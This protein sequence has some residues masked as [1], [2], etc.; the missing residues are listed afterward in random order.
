[1]SKLFH[2]Y[3]KFYDPTGASNDPHGWCDRLMA[4]YGVTRIPALM[5]GHI[6]ADDDPA[7]N[8]D[9]DEAK[10]RYQLTHG[11]RIPQDS[12]C[13]FN[14]ENPVHSVWKNVKGSDDVEVQQ[15]GIDF[16]H[17][18]LD[19]AENERPDVTLGI[20]GQVPFSGYKFIANE[21]FVESR[22]RLYTA[23]RPLADRLG[24]LLPE[25]YDRQ[26]WPG[27]MN[28]FGHRL[29]WLKTVLEGARYHYSG[30]TLIPMLW[31]EYIDLWRHRPDPDTEEAQIARQLSGLT[32]LRFNRIV[33]DLADGVMWWG[34]GSG[35]NSGKNLWKADS[36]WWDAS[37]EM[38]RVYGQ[39]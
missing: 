6:F 36:E 19:V 10:F 33:L 34:G 2:H 9:F 27:S 14:I 24:F 26:L 8:N 17:R 18:V 11:D 31:P 21:R 7:G 32:W 38:F 29:Q 5:H 3:L 37:K 15:E 30:K 4:P 28:T 35:S 22:E 1:M 13:W 20:F 39:N 12:W 25:F 16:F 23:C